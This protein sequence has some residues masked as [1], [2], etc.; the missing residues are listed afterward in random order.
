MNNPCIKSI[1]GNEIKRWSIE[2]FKDLSISEQE[3]IK[4]FIIQ[5]I[6]KHIQNL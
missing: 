6:I 2:N 1:N 5:T 4:I 3:R